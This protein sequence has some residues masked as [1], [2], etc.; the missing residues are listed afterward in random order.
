[1]PENPNLTGFQAIPHEPHD[2]HETNEGR[3]FRP[4]PRSI[5]PTVQR[6]LWP[7]RFGYRHG[8]G[9]P[10]L[11]NRLLASIDLKPC[12]YGLSGVSSRGSRASR[13]AMAHSRN[14]REPYKIGTQLPDAT[15]HSPPCRKLFANLREFAKCPVPC[16]RHTD[17]RV[18]GF[19][20]G[21]YSCVLRIICQCEISHTP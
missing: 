21:L 7:P 18:R 4:S 12:P 5:C 15:A 3:H 19:A 1:M 9:S 2:S 17:W 11:E 8:S 13:V 20:H 6:L 14:F 16:G 10:S